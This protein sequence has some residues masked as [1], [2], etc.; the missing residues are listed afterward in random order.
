MRFFFA[1]RDFCPKS[2]KIAPREKKIARRDFSQKMKNWR[3][4]S[5]RD[6]WRDFLIQHGAIFGALFV[7]QT[8]IR[9]RVIR[10][11]WLR[12][13][14]TRRI[15]YGFTHL[16]SWPPYDHPPSFSIG[17]AVFYRSKN[18]HFARLKRNS[19]L[20]FEA[21]YLFSGYNYLNIIIF[22]WESWRLKV[23]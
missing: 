20:D 7:N 18:R 6:F 9:G 12:Q 11:P 16:K 5:R 3:Q 8:T 1:R 23:S 22:S 2:H 21:K 13:W 10:R 4:K 19:P 14:Q 15:A 17:S